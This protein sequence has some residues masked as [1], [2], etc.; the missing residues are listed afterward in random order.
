MINLDE[1]KIKRLE[2]RERA[3]KGTAGNEP[4]KKTA[5]SESQHDSF[6]STYFYKFLF[7]NGNIMPGHSQRVGFTEKTD[8]QHVLINW[9]LRMYKIGYLDYHNPTKETIDKIEVYLNAREGKKLL[10]VLFLDYYEVHT[11]HSAFMVYAQFLDKF[12][13]SIRK[14]ED[15]KT[16][17]YKYFCNEKSEKI[18][19]FDIKKRRWIT[20]AA[21]AN[22]CKIMYDK[23]VFTL[24][25]AQ[26]FERKYI[27]YH[28]LKW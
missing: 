22:Y 9:T 15:V 28:N 27:E 5:Y 19:P 18:D 17:Y 26:Y 8:K 6:S 7:K 11:E 14:K 20:S 23:K 12:Y 13:E 2:A 1:K 24:E 3:K 25:Q 10:F 21:L 4:Q 16:I